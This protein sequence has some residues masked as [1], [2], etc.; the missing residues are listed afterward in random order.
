M[1]RW[2]RDLC[3]PSFLVIRPPNV[4]DMKR[5]ANAHAAKCK[6]SASNCSIS[7][8]TLSLLLQPSPL[9]P[10]P[11]TKPPSR[12]CS[13]RYR[14]WQSSSSLPLVWYRPGMV[15]RMVKVRRS[16]MVFPLQTS[17]AHQQ[18]RHHR[19]LRLPV[20]EPVGLPPQIVASQE[21]TPKMSLMV[22]PIP[23][24]TPPIIQMLRCR[25]KSP[26]TCRLHDT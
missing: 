15:S 11:H 7:L 2:S 5:G 20:I 4:L 1:R 23:S 3:Q 10:S 17:R 16:L 25:I 14:S 18:K 8:F 13:E 6:I 12:C 21:T 26:S 24:G 22:I 9:I 19:L